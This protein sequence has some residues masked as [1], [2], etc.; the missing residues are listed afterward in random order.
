MQPQ[1][2][3]EIAPAARL[4]E[5][6]TAAVVLKCELHSVASRG[7]NNFDAIRTGMLHRISRSV[8]DVTASYDANSR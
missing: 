8:A 3:G 2:V 7:E 1:T 4:L 6:K 5:I